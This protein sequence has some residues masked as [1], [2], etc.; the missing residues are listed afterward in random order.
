MSGPDVDVLV[1][2]SG[3]AG[4]T[5]A[6]EASAAG[7][8][9]LVAEAGTVIG[10]ATRLSSGIVM[11][12]GTR[13]QRDHGIDDTPRAL[14]QHYMAS[15]QWKI[16][17]ACVKR[18]CDE[19]GLTIEWLVDLGAKVTGLIP[20]GDE[21]QPRG[22]AF[23]GGGQAIVDLLHGLLRQRP[24]V[25]FALGR[26]VDRFLVDAAGRVVGAAV[27]D[28]AVRAGAVIVAMGGTG[29]NFDV[30]A[31]YAPEP[32][33]AAGDWAF[34]Y[35]PDTCQGD[36]LTLAGQVDAQI[37][38]H[39]RQI[40]SLRPNFSEEPAMYLP[41]WLVVV[42][43]AGRR[44]FD[45]TSPYSVTQGLVYA[46]GGPVYAVF[47]D[48]AKRASQPSSTYADTKVLIEG[49]MWEDWVEPVIDEN[50]ARGKVVC[51]DTVEE[52]AE[53]IGVPAANLAGTVDRYNEGVRAGKDLFYLKEPGYMRPVDT[54]P[55]YATELRVR[56]IG[57]SATG[58]RIDEDGRVLSNRS[59]PI[60]GLYAAGE[61][62]GGIIGDIY[63]GSGNS[64]AQCLTYGRIA[65]RTA[66]ADLTRP[67]S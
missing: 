3:G 60:P 46:Q 65:G 28:D 15:N 24:G 63:M 38:G 47:D 9:V 14:F 54:P 40:N 25:E 16:E 49:A 36:A 43:R 64:L 23:D 52:L 19:A 1:L 8:S 7:A 29:G 32:M 39:G 45:E 37:I 26:R 51:R 30:A 53:A 21:P 10:G 31:R 22:H 50:L 42:N 6:V 12:A 17:T 56:M 66:V 2:G 67:A 48:A 35:W 5:A 44:F 4:L 41:G 57:I 55:Y 11:G 62:V 33:A 34:T 61:C 18:L 13:L 20:S 58:L 27:G 59:A